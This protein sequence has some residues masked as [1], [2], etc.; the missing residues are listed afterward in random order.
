M[1]SWLRE[2]GDDAL[3]LSVHVQPGAKQTGFAGL[4]GGALKLRLAAPPVDGKANAA[5]CRFLAEYCEVPKSAVTLV[6]G[7]SSRAKRVRIA[8]LGGAARERLAAL[9]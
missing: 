1:S 6:S 8:G 5:L 2:D 3:I 9:G 4:Y 7:L